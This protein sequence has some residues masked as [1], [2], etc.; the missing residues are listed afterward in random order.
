MRSRALVLVVVLSAAAALSGCAGEGEQPIGSDQPDRVSTATSQPISPGRRDIDLS[1]AAEA[2]QCEL[3]A[4]GQ[5]CLL[6][7]WFANQ[8]TRAV[9]LDAR[10]VLVVDSSGTPY[11]VRTEASAAEVVV[12]PFTRSLVLMEVDLPAGARAQQ[13][14]WSPST[15]P[16]LSYAFPGVPAPSPSPTPSPTPTPS[17]APPAPTPS[18]TSA[19]PAPRPTTPRPTPAPTRTRTSAPPAPAPPPE[20]APPPTA[21]VGSI[22]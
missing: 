12:V 15:G 22:G 10:S 6:R 4:E 9:K 11:P 18:P 1:V 2:P 21:P 16:D 7:V 14:R 19:S 5:R 13:V 3:R 8:T 17:S 20:P